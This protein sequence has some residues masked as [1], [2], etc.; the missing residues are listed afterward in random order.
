M[1]SPAIT[2]AEFIR[3]SGGIYTSDDSYEQ[4]SSYQKWNKFWAFFFDT[5]HDWVPSVYGEIPLSKLRKHRR[6]SIEHIIPRSV[7]QNTLAQSDASLELINGA[8]TNPF[9]LAPSDR[10][11]NKTRASFP[12]DL[13]GDRVHRPFDIYMNPEAKGKTGLD[14]EQEWVI[15]RRS[16][17]DVARAILYMMVIYNLD[18]LYRAHLSTLLQW[19]QEDEPL[20]WEIAYN[21]WM[22]KHFHICNP[23]ITTPI[24]R[25][26]LD[27]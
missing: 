8:T 19:S 27:R 22:Q 10:F 24:H 9:N 12:F 21:R 4:W 3:R 11:L 13:D 5:K 17:G 1:K 6:L 14:I 26:Q 16:R 7:L 20:D 18:V 23:L 2:R 15:P 25:F